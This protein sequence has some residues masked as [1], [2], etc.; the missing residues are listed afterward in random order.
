MRKNVTTVSHS[1]IK[2][3]SLIEEVSTTAQAHI[4][5]LFNLT[6][7]SQDKKSEFKSNL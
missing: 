4:N 6:A 2:T 3:F 1:K 7:N 5:I